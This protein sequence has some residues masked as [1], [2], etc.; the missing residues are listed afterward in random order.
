M[1]ECPQSFSKGT[2]DQEEY[3]DQQTW[4]YI[5]LGDSRYEPDQLLYTRIICSA[6]RPFVELAYFSILEL[7]SLI[8]NKWLFNCNCQ[9][10]LLQTKCLDAHC[11]NNVK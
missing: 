4:A 1:E 10:T 6:D 7:W 2:V 5:S 3:C 11:L 8:K 9:L